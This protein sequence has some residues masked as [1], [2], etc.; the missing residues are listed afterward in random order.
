MLLVDSYPSLP[1]IPWPKHLTESSVS[2][3]QVCLKPQC[4]DLA[5]SPD[6]KL[7]AGRRSPTLCSV[8]TLNGLL[9]V[10]MP[11]NPTWMVSPVPVSPML[12]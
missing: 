8:F 3:T 4:T 5:S 7:T 6:P 11:R 9:E 10:P 1:F 12:P 2:T